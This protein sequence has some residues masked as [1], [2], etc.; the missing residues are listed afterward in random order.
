[1]PQQNKS[2]TD[3]T[4]KQGGNQP[5][6]GVSFFGAHRVSLIMVTG[7]VV[8]A[9]SG[10][11]LN[12]FAAPP[13]S[14]YLPGE[15]LAPSCAPGAT[16]C[17]VIPPALSGANADITS[18]TGL[19]TALPVTEGGTGLSSITMGKL[20]YASAANTL[21]ELSISS[22]LQLTGNTLDVNEANFALTST[23]ISDFSTA[24]QSEIT[25]QK[26]IASGI[27]SLNASG[28]VPSSQ[29]SSQPINN[30]FVVADQTARLALAGSAVVG[31]VAVQ[32]DNTTTYILQTLTGSTD[33]DWV[34]LST[35]AAVTSVNGQTGTVTLT[36]GSI[37][38]TLPVA[39]G[40]T[41]AAT[42][43]AG[44]NNLLPSQGGNS[45]K[46]LGTNGT[47]TAWVTN[48]AGAAWGTITGTLS[49][50][51]DLTTALSGK[52]ANGAN[53]DITSL[54]AVTA[55]TSTGALTLT[56]GGSNN[57]ITLTPAG[58]G[59]VAVAGTFGIVE[60]GVSPTFY[61][62]FV[63]ADQ[64][65]DI[66]YTLPVDDGTP[67]Q[68]LTTDGSG[69]LS[70]TTAAGGGSV[71]TL[72]DVTLTS[73]A[74]NDFL[75]YNGTAWVNKTPA[76]VKT[77]IGAAA[78]GAN[79]DI[80]SLSGLTTALSIAQGGTGQIT[81]NAALN[82]L[83]PL[84]TGNS[85]KVL[86]TDGTNTA[87]VAAGGG[88]SV[89][90]LSDVTLTGLAS[91][92]FLKYNGA[93]WVNRTSAQTRGDIGAAVSGAN[94]DIT[95]LTATTSVA[96]SGALALSAGGTNQDVSITSS[97]TGAVIAKPGTDSA[98][99]FEIRRA[100]NVTR[101]FVVD[102][103]TST[104]GFSILE[105]EATP[106]LYTR[107]RTGDQAANLI[108]TLPT[109]APTA[110]QVLSSSG[111][112]TSTL[113]WATAGT[114]DVVGPA[115]STDNAVARFDLATGKLLQNSVVTISD[116]G[117][118]AG[119]ATLNT[120]TI[121][122]GTST[123]ALLS[124]NLG[125]FAATTSAQLAGVLSDETGTGVFVLATSPTLTTPNIGVATAT[126]V[127][128]LTI[129]TPATGSTL[130]IAD[131]KTLTSSNTLTFTGTDGSSVAF[132]AG[133]TVVYASDLGSYVATSGGTLTG[134][135]T[136]SGVAT[137]LTSA[138]TEDITIAS[139][140]TG[141]VVLKPGTGG[142]AAGAI[143]FRNA[144]G[145][146]I[147]TID[148]G[149]SALVRLSVLGTAGGD[150]TRLGVIAPAS[151][152]AVLALLPDEADPT[153]PT[154]SKLMSI[155]GKASGDMVMNSAGNIN[156]QAGGTTSNINL[157]PKGSTG[158][159]VIDGT[160]G[161]A[162][163]KI[164]II[165]FGASPGFT[166]TLT[167][168]NVT[169][170]RTI[171]FPDATGTVA[172]TSQLVSPTAT[173]GLENVGG[174]AIK[175]DST[176]DG[177][178]TVATSSDGTRI[179]NIKNANIA[180]DASIDRT[181][182]AT[183]ALDQIVVNDGATGALT[184]IATLDVTRGGTGSDLSATGGASQV[185]KQSTVGGAISVGQLAT[186]DISGLG[187]IATQSASSVT[188]T[189]GTINGTTIGGSTP[190][191][192]TFTSL[193]AT[194]TTTINTAISGLLKA[195]AGV[196]SAASGGTDF[197][198][199]LTFNL[200][201]SRSVNAISISQ[202]DGSTDGYLSSTDWNT[203]NGKASGG[204]NSDITSLTALTLVSVADNSGT[205]FKIGQGSDDYFFI[206]T[207]NGSEN[208]GFGNSTTNPDFT[209]LGTG[210]FNIS[211]LSTGVVHAD[212][213]GNLSS[214]AVDLSTETTGSLAAANGGTGI[215]SSALTGIATITSGTWSAT[216]TTGTGNIVLATSPTLTTPNIGVATA[217]TVNK[218]T[219]TT[220]ATGSTLTIADGKTLT[221]SNTLTLTGTDSSSVAF[222]TGGTVAYTSSN[223]G[224]FAATTSA[225]LAGVISD[226][227]G[228]GAL[229]FG[230]APAF[231]TSISTP[232]V[233]STGDVA[234]KPGSNTTTAFK[235]R[236][237]ADDFTVLSVDTNDSPVG[238]ALTVGAKVGH[239]RLGVVAVVGK[240]SAL[241]LAPNG[242][243]TPTDWFTITSHSS[244][245]TD[246][247][248]G[249]AITMAAGGTN[250]GI[251]LKTTGTGKTI[252]Q[253]TTSTDDKIAFA[254]ATGG[255][256]SFTA[257][258]SETELTGDQTFTLPATGGTFLTS[259]A[260][261]T[262][263]QGGTGTTNGSI[264][265]TG[266]LTFTAGG[267][268]QDASLISSGTGKVILKVGSDSPGSSIELRKADNSVML[269]ATP[270]TGNIAMNSNVV[271]TLNASLLQAFTIQDDSNN[272]LFVA[273]S[274][275]P[276][277]TFG[278][279]S[280][281]PGFNFS[282]GGT[283]DFGTSPVQ[284]S[285]TFDIN[286]N[287]N[288]TLSVAYIDA[289][290]LTTAN[291]LNV[292][293]N[294]I[295]TGKVLNVS[296]TSTALTSATGISAIF[297]GNPAASWTGSVGIFENSSADTDVDGN[298]LKVG[299]TGAAAG[300]GTALNVTTAQT[301]TGALA[302]RVNDDGTY[303]DSTPFIIDASGTAL[304]GTT[305]T[306]NHIRLGEKLGVV[307]VGDANYGGMAMT[308][309]SG[310]TDAN[311]SPLL[312]LQRSRGTTDGTLTVVAS[313]DQL[314]GLYFRG[315][316]SN[317]FESGA[318]IFAFSDGTPGNGDM[319]GRLSLYT[320]ADG[321]ASLTE[322]LRIDSAGFVGIGTQAAVTLAGKLHVAT[323]GT[324]QTYWDNYSTAAGDHVS[325]IFR[326]SDNATLGT[327]TQTVDTDNLG[328][329][330][331]K[332]VNSSGAFANGAFIKAQQ[333]GASGASFVP[334]DLKFYTATNAADIAERMRIESDGDVGI[335]TAGAAT[336]RLD[337]V[338]DNSSAYAARI[339][340]DGN[341]ANRKGLLIIAGEDAP[342]GASGPDG[343][344]IQ[345]QDGDGTDA[346]EI[347]FTS[348]TTSYSASSD[349]RMKRDIQDT[350]KGLS[351]LMKIQ[352]RDYH[353]NADVA[354]APLHTGY[355]AQELYD[356]YPEAVTAHT[357]S[358]KM[359]SVDY[360][361]ITPLIVQAVQDQQKEIIG[362]QGDVE[363][364]KKLVTASRDI[365]DMKA[366]I[367]TLDQ[368][369]LEV[370]AL[371]GRL[372]SV[373]KKV[374][375]HSRD[376]EKLQKQVEELQKEIKKKE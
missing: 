231:T 225:Q 369:V 186:T 94:S 366:Q 129:T 156:I 51:T 128:K 9:L 160:N 261:V 130:T 356:V 334:A 67:G 305:T 93:A 234:V 203:F 3:K 101:V 103:T 264:T 157:K 147:A 257:T 146:D 120:H 248:G 96:S 166:L 152:D 165:P 141:K 8:L 20:L 318:G 291:A 70:W 192:G 250:K 48:A 177:Y 42:A 326:K 55:L 260:A 254:P 288:T 314:G 263:A 170:A 92:D 151:K 99:A 47:D 35:P 6:F 2:N 38:G 57:S 97:G 75:Q 86:G 45:G 112:A 199:P 328:S 348:T 301:G 317:S 332:G 240:D 136:F 304:L 371:D 26:G 82:A 28:K 46:I 41:G 342:D 34:V 194:G 324:Q 241:A 154:F 133:G 54:T 171:T 173:G 275:A 81:A 108:Y 309:Y 299:L 307:S 364:L 220:P 271:T 18:L 335:G 196:V 294:V 211:S 352:V 331:F 33:G 213:S 131:G 255:A 22:K 266:A 279:A 327:I 355:I 17:T 118:I 56:A 153:A 105:N 298:A 143:S 85:G 287:T 269:S 66:L 24:T 10:A 247:A 148:T 218:L 62:K 114:G 32:T 126:T 12:T 172:L 338:Y 202:A 188:I 336:A 7:A 58:T 290:T 310:T 200:P 78:S 322:R 168:E 244:Y 224:A 222:G 372:D 373:E 282:G 360:G 61:T 323:T 185:L 169:A 249:G 349:R 140:T 278:N 137:D 1:M 205:A 11:L 368:K 337:V 267:T 23:N 345:F 125:A 124:N 354:N 300:D 232:L 283:V 216:A 29:L 36:F 197:E 89:A 189:G 121:P 132:G 109:T 198:N 5:T 83:L 210:T 217:T 71:S 76:Q 243:G 52:A 139:G 16:N 123:L 84:Q 207:T 180:S 312:E 219:I 19:T 284:G 281:N 350:V 127:N 251:T 265:G 100:D 49:S 91:G 341:N 15:T 43:N 110:G 339:F 181:K 303:T 178:A 289:N 272:P 87:W 144:A 212:G 191:A 351:D 60:G 235:V 204:A 325:M 215:N 4:L 256:A 63:G 102:T 375:K 142:D 193:T 226:E 221:A 149:A 206:D 315:A 242:S 237:A 277:L 297:S 145:T 228:T 98:N 230:T 262:V 119:A 374:D 44:L 64:A 163:D 208:I 239:A 73:L 357:D 134:G 117:D 286:N 159:V 59:Q 50:Q 253:T 319:P 167:N 183:G 21:S 175:I 187:T 40:G 37:S 77:S 270:D 295:T 359:W 258:I 330:T 201:L 259:G 72:T 367:A 122:G 190:A 223:L 135:L 308:S 365:K 313:G 107:F 174:L 164:A 95:S 65:A 346:G 343:T 138:A 195:T 214:S 111:G 376:I 162:S 344:L 276:S 233:T 227:T 150:H 14:Q 161:G 340:N 53:A 80:T 361:K 370:A 69:L 268:N 285:S 30:T 229:V 155:E 274:S 184:S 353:Y 90:T 293:A 27:A 238:G 104:Y 292:S 236:N 79:S 280:N 363:G 321:S 273:D 347:T 302:F 116:T 320:T 311:A 245:D 31:D 88:G 306:T 329:L 113:T 358:D 246:L 115:S 296:S 252:L 362:L 333:S 74:T 316:D 158:T 13:G 209:F 182:I 68:V 176:T 25:N 39:Q 106:S 179:V